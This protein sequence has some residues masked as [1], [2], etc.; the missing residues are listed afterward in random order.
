MS[1]A[2]LNQ[3]TR[4]LGTS[5]DGSSAD[6]RVVAWK[7][8][9][10]HSQWVSLVWAALQ[11]DAG[12]PAPAIA[13]DGEAGWCLL[14][15]L[16]A[17]RSA[18]E[19]RSVLR[20]LITAALRQ[21]DVAVSSTDADAWTFVCWPADL[22]PDQATWPPVPRQTGPDRWSAFVAPDLVPVFADTPWLD[23]APGEEGQAALL[24]RLQPVALSTWER[25]LAAAQ[26][27]A[28]LLPGHAAPAEADRPQGGATVAAPTH[29]HTD[30][31]SH[32]PADD[33]RAFLL[34]VMNDPQVDLGHR[35][36]AA[37]A[38]LSAG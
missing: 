12:L 1:S 13:V 36:E 26:A 19:A 21:A 14:V 4:L 37:R 6:A 15:A 22:A 31:H 2:L 38:L 18:D 25:C 10:R 20:H 3:W 32:T 24:S 35:I 33:A 17:G 16:P 11:A 9:A 30:T 28:G 34:K 8:G 27:E 7:V 29:T 23:C 5:P